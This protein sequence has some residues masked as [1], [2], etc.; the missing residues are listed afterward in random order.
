MHYIGEIRALEVELIDAATAHLFAS[1]Q[2]ALFTQQKRE[3]CGTI[4]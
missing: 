4:K 1:Q 3:P 2:I